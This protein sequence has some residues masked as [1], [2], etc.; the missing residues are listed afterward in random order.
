MKVAWMV[1]KSLACLFA[2][3]GLSHDTLSQVTERV[4]LIGSTNLP[5]DS[6]DKSGLSGMLETNTPVNAFGG[7]SAIDYSGSGNRYVVLSDRGAGDGAASFPCRFHFVELKLDREKRSIDFRLDETSMLRDAQGAAMTGS[8]SVLKA[9]DRPERCP[10]FDPE[11]I[12]SMGNAGVIISD[13]YGPYID[14]FSKEGKHIR[15][16]AI[17]KSFLLSEKQTPSL[18]QGAFSNR[19]LEGVAVSPDGRTIIG[20]MQGPLVQDGRIEKNKCLGVWTRWIVIDAQ[21]GKSKQWVYRL[22]DE[23]TGVS[24]VLWVDANRFLVLERDSNA[25]EAAKIKK[26][27]LADA[28][29][30]SD[31]SQVASMRQGPP[32]G[33]VILR[34][35]LLIDLLNP[36]YGFSGSQAPEKPEGITWGPM[37]DDGR[38]LL[39]VCFDNDFEPANPTIFAAFAVRL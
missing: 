20:A 9:W 13:E 5:G 37:L 39:M 34:K 30:V 8:L 27:Y 15:N 21:S 18:V 29:G 6:T 4:E 17:P 32:N 35:E 14:Q 31:I 24:E 19:G 16:F 10:S 1:P 26:I 12:R 11:G 36:A 3:A 28:T 25:G 33:T 38:R 22:D 23:S 2:L 7:L